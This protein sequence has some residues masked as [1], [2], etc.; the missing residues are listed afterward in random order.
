[1]ITMEDWVTIKNLKK[2]NNDMGIKT[3]AR[4]MKIS[5]NTVKRAL[6][7]DAVPLYQ[8]KEIENPDVLPF[9]EYIYEQLVVKHL[10][11]SR[12]LNDICSKGYKG[13]KS[14]FY[15]YLIKI[16]QTSKRTY[17]PYETGAGEQA[18][19]DWSEYT[20]V[21]NR[22]LTKVY[23]FSYILSFSRYRIY[24]A[25]LSQTQGSVFEAMENS[26]YQTAGVA[27]RIQTDNATC[28]V[29]NAARN[30]LEW[31]KRYLQFCGHFGFQPSRSLP[32]HPW[33]KGKVEKPFEYLEDHFIKGNE[34]EDFGDFLKRLKDFQQQVNEKVHTTTKRTPVELFAQ[35][36]VSLTQLP[37]SRYVNIKEQ[38]RKV[39]ADCLF[40]FEGNK[41]SVPFL[42]ACREVWI[43]VSKGYYIEVYSD[44]NILIASHQIALNKGNVIINKEH[45][46]NHRLDRGNWKR[47]CLDFS[48]QFAQHEWFLDKLKTQ[49]K[50]N[51]QY[52]LAQ[53]LKIAGFY[54]TEDVI[55][56]LNTCKQYNVYNYSFINGFLQKNAK[57]K[58]PLPQPTGL[59]SKYL[60]NTKPVIANMDQY[61]L[62]F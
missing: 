34:F 29:T 36:K 12:V 61:K 23:V 24:E 20:I 49:K 1:M 32:G 8:R 55:V 57:V 44:K 30:N 31:N 10:K 47:L 9:K 35:E 26:F 54:E 52:H 13:S 60:L 17:Q 4:I 16:N 33:S 39:T 3:I 48:E 21:V 56:A 6:N 43:R 28:F 50:L 18:Q 51:A 5:R 40:S 11:G 25:S 2:R 38:V 62:N 15:R 22:V 42:F 41:Y 59:S 46:K 53:L 14:S 58:T 45:Y 27:E 37:S 7:T 19:F